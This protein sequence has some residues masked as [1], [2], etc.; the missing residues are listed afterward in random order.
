MS[1]LLESKVFQVKKD[2]T[3]DK[4]HTYPGGAKPETLQAHKVQVMHLI[5]T[6]HFEC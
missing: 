2:K 6:T 3:D 1:F 5:K 4:L